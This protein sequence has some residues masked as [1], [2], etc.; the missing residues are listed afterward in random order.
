MRAA[1]PADEGDPKVGLVSVT[2]RRQCARPRTLI[3][4]ISD[5]E[6]PILRQLIIPPNISEAIEKTTQDWSKV[7]EEEGTC[8]IS[9]GV[10]S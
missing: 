5:R 7:N 3:F 1:L 10:S 2:A 6:V 9:A 4:L 8:A